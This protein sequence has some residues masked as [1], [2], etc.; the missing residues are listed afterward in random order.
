MTYMTKLSLLTLFD[1]VKFKQFSFLFNCL[2]I[3]Y[4]DHHKRNKF[5]F[6]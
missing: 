1:Y 3:L 2:E 5:I 4:N 6:T